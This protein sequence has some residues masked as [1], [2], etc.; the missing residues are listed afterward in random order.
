MKILVANE[1]LVLPV[2][3]LQLITEAEALKGL[4]STIIT[5]ASEEVSFHTR[6]KAY[7]STYLPGS[8]LDNETTEEF[9][10]YLHRVFPDL[11]KADIY[12][13]V[14]LL[15]RTRV[16]L[17]SCIFMC[18]DRFG[19]ELASEPSDLDMFG[20]ILEYINKHF[21]L[22]LEEDDINIQAAVSNG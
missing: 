9:T 16:E 12:H 21:K 13:I 5:T 2:E 4:D 3:A 14:A 17:Y 20:Q 18:C 8:A 10:K 11:L 15:P 19:A 1:S 22:V 6:L 7:I